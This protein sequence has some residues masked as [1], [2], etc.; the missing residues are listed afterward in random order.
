MGIYKR[1]NTPLNRGAVRAF[2]CF[3]NNSLSYLIFKRIYGPEHSR[4]GAAKLQA[5]IGLDVYFISCQFEDLP[6]QYLNIILSSGKKKN[7][8]II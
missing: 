7:V 2:S 4:V 8:S 3:T 6:F 5:Y 1:L